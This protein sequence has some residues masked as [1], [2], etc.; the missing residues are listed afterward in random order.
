MGSAMA[1]T[2]E[3]RATGVARV[4]AG[5]SRRKVAGEMGV[6]DATVRRWITQSERRET[7][8]DL[9]LADRAHKIADQ[10]EHWETIARERLIRRVVELARESEDLAAVTNAYSKVTEKAMLRAGKPTSITKSVDQMDT[11]IEQM[12]ATMAERESVGSRNGR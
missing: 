5:E 6:S 10:I 9:D 11:E 2:F 1:Y 12:L 4:L 8:Q 3:Q 7:A